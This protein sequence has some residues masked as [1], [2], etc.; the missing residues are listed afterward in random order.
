[1]ERR[2]QDV[3]PCA[4]HIIPVSPPITPI[5]FASQ[6]IRLS[7]HLY[8]GKYLF[9]LNPLVNV[10]HVICH[11]LRGLEVHLFNHLDC[12]QQVK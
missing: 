3:L 8:Q 5:R 11:L 6:L 12:R 9:N 1:M 4:V 7:H 10:N 2:H